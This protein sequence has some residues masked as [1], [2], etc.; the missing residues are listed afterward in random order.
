VEVPRYVDNL[1]EQSVYYEKLIEVPIE[2][3]I[4]RPYYVE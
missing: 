2:R 3:V 1:I 4:D